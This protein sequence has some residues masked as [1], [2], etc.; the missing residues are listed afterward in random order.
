[1]PLLCEMTL[2]E[3]LE[4]SRSVWS[5]IDTDPSASSHV[6]VGCPHCHGVNPVPKGYDIQICICNECGKNF[7]V[8][9]M[10]IGPLASEYYNATL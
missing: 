9:K 3:Q 2:E 5:S 6:G 10:K 8:T 7:T 4:Y 1:M